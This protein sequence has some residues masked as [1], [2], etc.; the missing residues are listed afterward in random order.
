MGKIKDFV[1]KIKPYTKSQVNNIIAKE[2]ETA[3]QEE[4]QW[5]MKGGNP[6]I[7]IGNEPQDYFYLYEQKEP[8]LKQNK[9]QRAMEHFVGGYD[10]YGSTYPAF[11]S[12]QTVDQLFTMQEAVYVKYF[13]DPHCRSIIDNW[14]MYTIGGGLKL[15]IDNPKVEKVIRD[16]RQTNDMVKREKQLIKM[17][18]IE[19]ELFIAYYINPVNGKVKIR[20]IRP[21]EIADIETHP[22]DIETKFSYH[23][24]YDHSP[25]GT[26]QQYKRDIWIPDI[27]YQDYLGSPFGTRLAK[28]KKR[29]KSMP[30]VQMMKMGI[31]TEV[32]GRVPL[33]PVLRHLKYYEDWLMDRI[34]LNHERAKVVWI[35]EVRGRM[36][37]STE[38]NRRAPRGGVM[39]VETEN[40]KYRIEKPS[41]NAD[42]AKEDGLQILYTIGAGTSLPIHILNQRSDQQ[43]YASIRKA[44]TPFSQYIRGQQEFFESGFEKMYRTVITSAVDAG[45]LPKRVRIPEYSQESLLETM[46]KINEMIVDN[47]PTS[48]IKEQAEKMLQPSISYKPI[49]TADIPL[50]M[51][52]PEIIRED[53]EAQAKVFKIHKEIGIASAATLAAKA[54]YNWRQEL[55]NMLNENQ[56][57]TEPEDQ[58]E[59]PQSKD[60][61]TKP[62]PTNEEPPKGGTPQKKGDRFTGV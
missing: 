10:Y 30:L 32:R 38:R 25:M 48:Y 15:N 3:T 21:Q 36:P 56:M 16:F 57:F 5:H 58:F 39:L 33:S 17:C 44:E 60:K 35:K 24:E 2:R 41:I 49:N 42:D 23:W 40:V 43:V 55:A 51:E 19:G 46:T 6:S 61:D 7:G 34:R 14:T 59:K 27:G 12:D 22:E 62:A 11:Y 50:G 52:F 26:E 13:N 54:G 8:S 4:K 37:E 9:D 20:R 45:S 53:M 29:V 18:Y 1:K 31:D 47:K 28:S